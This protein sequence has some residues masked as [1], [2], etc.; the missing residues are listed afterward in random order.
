[1]ATLKKSKLNVLLKHLADG[2]DADEDTVADLL[3]ID[4]EDTES[5]NAYLRRAAQADKVETPS[6]AEP[7]VA[8]DVYMLK[9][10]DGF[11]V[12]LELI[13]RKGNLVVLSRVVAKDIVRVVVRG[14]ELTVD[15]EQLRKLAP[16]A[17][18]EGVKVSTLITAAELA[19]G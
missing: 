17:L 9:N 6:P 18:H 19:K 11:L 16:D 10:E 5:I 2:G 1:M 13:S 14:K 3:E 12:D 7:S 15:L 8:E 4:R